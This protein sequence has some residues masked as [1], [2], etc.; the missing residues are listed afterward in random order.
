MSPSNAQTLSLKIVHIQFLLVVTLWLLNSNLT[1]CRWTIKLGHFFYTSAN[2]SVN[3]KIRLKLKFEQ[4][5]HP[6]KYKFYC[7]KLES[8][9][10][11]LQ[12][13]H[14]YNKFMYGCMSVTIRIW[15]QIQLNRIYGKVL[16][17]QSI[18]YARTVVV[19]MPRIS[20]FLD[21]LR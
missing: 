20:I 1:W 4:T 9:P 8:K 21:E 10:I 2:Y 5:P 11:W 7:W 14:I 17:I 18:R 6:T 3:I 19:K 16:G 15:K 13:N 12:N